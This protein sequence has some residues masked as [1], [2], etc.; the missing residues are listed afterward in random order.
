MTTPPVPVPRSGRERRLLLED[1]ARLCDAARDDVRGGEP[2]RRDAPVMRAEAVAVRGDDREYDLHGER[3]GELGVA[4][5]RQDRALHW[6]AA[7][8]RVTAA[9]RRRG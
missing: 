5:H 8:P 3:D 1:A 2:R 4:G 6:I 7:E 9:G